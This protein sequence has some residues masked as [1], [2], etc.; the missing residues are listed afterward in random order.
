MSPAAARSAAREIA[1]ELVVLY[2]RRVTSE[3]HAFPQ[4]TPHANILVTM[5]SRAGVP[6]QDYEKF[7]DNT[8][9]FTEV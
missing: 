5:L 9:V 7:A 1:Q 3:G 4:D 6:T 8:G 2:R